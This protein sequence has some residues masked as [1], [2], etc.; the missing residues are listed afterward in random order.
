MGGAVGSQ[1]A[2]QEA[3]V[4]LRVERQLRIAQEVYD[5][6]EATRCTCRRLERN[7][8]GSKSTS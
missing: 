7:D 4:A 5:R 2:E 8:R 6:F 1:P 3:G